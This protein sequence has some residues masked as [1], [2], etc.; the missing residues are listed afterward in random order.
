MA[1]RLSALYRAVCPDFPADPTAREWF[2]G[3]LEGLLDHCLT[4]A[5]KAQHPN[6]FNRV[7]F[8]IARRR[9]ISLH[10]RQITEALPDAR[11][12]W[13]AENA[14]GETVPLP[15]TALEGWTTYPETPA[16]DFETGR[17]RWLD[18]GA[19]KG[20]VSEAEMARASALREFALEHYGAEVVGTVYMSKAEAENQ[21]FPPLGRG[22]QKAER[23]ARAMLRQGVPLDLTAKEARLELDNAGQAFKGGISDDI[24]KNAQKIAAKKADAYLELTGT[25]YTPAH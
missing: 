24:I 3:E 23:A 15:A 7:P 19:L 10:M 14:N 4:P 1:L 22:N 21:I 20:H 17:V 9:A 25:P 18:I 6:L 16:V 8:D 11:G 13:K 5:E 12:A 2:E